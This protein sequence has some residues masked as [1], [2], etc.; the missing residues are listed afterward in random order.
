MKAPGF[1]QETVITKLA[2]G[3]EEEGQTFEYE[4]F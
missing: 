2:S 3:K 1:L 4:F